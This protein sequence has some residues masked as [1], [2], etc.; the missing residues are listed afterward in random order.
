MGTL[1]VV[2]F[3]RQRF[4]ATWLKRAPGLWRVRRSSLPVFES[5]CVSVCVSMFVAGVE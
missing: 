4:S 2:C 1:Y 3:A 5:V